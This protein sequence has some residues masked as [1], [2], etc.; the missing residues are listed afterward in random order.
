[1]L[2]YLSSLQVNVNW[3]PPLLAPISENV[4]TVSVPIV[5]SIGPEILSTCQLFITSVRVF[6]QT[7]Q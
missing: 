5:D 2:D 7:I 4:K 3:L 1:M 6:I